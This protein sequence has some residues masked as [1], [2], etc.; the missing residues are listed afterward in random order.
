MQQQKMG[1]TFVEV[2]ASCPTNWKMSP[3]RANQ[4]V[5]SELIPLFPLAVF[6]E[7]QVADFE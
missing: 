4:R 5:E 6:K 2:L 3:E 7:R 1:F